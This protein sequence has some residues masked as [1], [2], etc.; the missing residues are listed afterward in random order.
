MWPMDRVAAFRELE[1]VYADLEAELAERRPRCELSGRC[2]RFA[3]VGHQLWT[4]RLELEYL[5][6]HAGPPPAG[7]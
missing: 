4:T 2:C 3:E 1:R 5:R 6:E 7:R